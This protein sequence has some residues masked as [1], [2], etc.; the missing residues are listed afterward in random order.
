VEQL[1]ENILDS[2]NKVKAKDLKLAFKQAFQDA[3]REIFGDSKYN[4]PE[5]STSVLTIKVVDRANSKIL[6]GADFA[7]IYDNGIIKH[8]KKSRQYIFNES[9][10]GHNEFDKIDMIKRDGYWEEFK[11]LYLYKKDNDP[12]R[13]SSSIRRETANDIWMWYYED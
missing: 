4:G 13:K 7:I 2:N 11:D 3:V 9:S 8:D 12:E 1:F 6:Y 5:D 10:S